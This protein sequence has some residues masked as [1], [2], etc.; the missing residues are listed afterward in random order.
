[1]RWF[2]EEILDQTY[3]FFDWIF[4]DYIWIFLALVE[5][6]CWMAWLVLIIGLLKKAGAV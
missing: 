1:M 5:W 4:G 2:I 6:T 3:V